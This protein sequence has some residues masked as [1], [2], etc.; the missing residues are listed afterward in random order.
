M[1]QVVWTRRALADLQAIHGYIAQFAP[2]AAQ[3]TA[4]RLEEAGNS[5]KDFPERGRLLPGSRRRELVSV[6]PYLLRYELW[7]IGSKF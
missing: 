4:R 5:L 6:R 7:A 1:V 3:R 2:I